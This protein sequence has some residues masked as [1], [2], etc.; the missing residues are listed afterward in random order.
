MRRVPLARRNLLADKRRLA[1]SV[2]GVGLAVMLI[3]LLEGLWTGVRQQSRALSAKTGGDLFV[4]QPGVRDLTP[5]VGT[6]PLSVLDTVRADPDVAWAAPM[7][8]AFVILQLHGRKVPVA[9]IGSV[10][11][12]R[13]GAWSVTSGRGPR[14]DNEIVISNVLAKRHGIAV[15]DSLDVMG[16]AVRVVGRSDATGYMFS[17]VFTTH[18]ALD[19]LAGT[20]GS[21]NVVLIGTPKPA[22]VMSRLRAEGLNVLDRAT[23]GANDVKFAVGIF[24][25]PIKLMVGIGFVGGTLIIALT[26]YTAIIERRREYGIVKAMG[27][28]RRLLLQWALSQTFVFAGLGLVAG[29][30]LFAFGRAAI[31]AT[32]P[33]FTIVLT[34]TSVAQAAAAAAVMALVAA[35]VPARRLAAI[36]PA[37]AYRS[38]A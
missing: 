34:R 9:V 20:S 4:M 27:A 17:F 30:G 1:A 31:V 16:H 10:P 36:E 29:V 26:A 38:A 37:A 8:T 19:R 14:A 28:T 7:R 12:Q 32:S 18:S 2:V 5:G 23:V 3:L 13:G 22:E 33:Q 35:V 6:V 21:T 11:G 25:S 24:G 15:G